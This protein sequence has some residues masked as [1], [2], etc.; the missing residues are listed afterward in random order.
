MKHLQVSIEIIKEL[1]INVQ[2]YDTVGIS[3][4]QM[5]KEI[6]GGENKGPFDSEQSIIKL[7]LSNK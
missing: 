3:K 6:I 1:H 5:I 4:H 7:F 2:N